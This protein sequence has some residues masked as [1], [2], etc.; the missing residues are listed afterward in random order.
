MPKVMHTS[1]DAIPPPAGRDLYEQ[2]E[3]QWM[4]E[5]IAALVDGDFGR[6]DREHLI[7]YLTDTTIRDRRELRSRLTVLLL[8]LLKVQYQPGRL[9]RSAVTTILDQQRE[10]RSIIEGIPSLGRQA[11][12]IAAAAYPDAVRQAARETRLQRA[13]FPADSP[14]TVAMALAFDPPEP[15]S[16]GKHH[17]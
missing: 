5:Q 2:D 8:H 3:H 13:G 16:R 9:T 14:W 15:A 11:D 10:I 17:Q 6:L 4:A 1:T 7:E 12:D